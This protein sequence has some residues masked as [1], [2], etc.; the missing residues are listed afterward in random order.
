M[1]AIFRNSDVRTSDKLKKYV[2][3]GDK[4]QGTAVDYV[5]MFG[6]SYKEIGGKVPSGYDKLGKVTK[7]VD[8]YNDIVDEAKRQRDINKLKSS[9]EA[10]QALG[11]LSAGIKIAKYVDKTG[12]LGAVA[13]ATV[14][15]VVRTAGQMEEQR[16][17]VHDAP[18][19]FPSGVG[20]HSGMNF[21]DKD[22]PN[23]K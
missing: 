20:E 13:D 1:V 5:M 23:L 17:I 14:G 19:E 12:Y 21:R 18:N 22:I 3:G 8:I 10:K 4:G 2:K 7:G 16:V 15:A 9:G 11:V 6:D